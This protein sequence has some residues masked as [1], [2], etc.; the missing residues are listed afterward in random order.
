[1]GSVENMNGNSSNT[2]ACSPF[3]A[4]RRLREML[5]DPS[6]LI[7]CPGVYDGLSARLVLSAGYD[8]MYMVRFRFVRSSQMTTR[9]M[10]SKRQPLIRQEQAC[11]CRDSAGQILDWPH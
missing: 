3:T 1:M 8:A 2:K 4:A 7:V 11:R 5:K 6:K 9:M 10:L